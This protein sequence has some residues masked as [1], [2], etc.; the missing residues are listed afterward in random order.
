[1]S[2]P[3]KKQEKGGRGGRGAGGGGDEESV[4]WTTINRSYSIEI[5]RY[6]KVLKAEEML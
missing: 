3:I 5:G 2:T 4:A 1:M 6:L